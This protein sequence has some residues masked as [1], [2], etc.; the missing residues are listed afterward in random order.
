MEE[1]KQN[2]KRVAKL[3]D[4]EIEKVFDEEYAQSAN[5]STIIK[6]FLLNQRIMTAGGGKRLRAAFMY[7]SYILFG[8]KNTSEILKV[9][10]SI[11]F[12]HA[13]LLIH[14][15][16]MDNANLRRGY[17]T[18]HSLYKKI[19]RKAQED[20][21][22]GKH[23]GNSIAINAGDS[24]SY[25]GQ[26]VLLESSF[27]ANKKIKAL[28]KVSRNIMDVVY[29]QVLDV[30]GDI[31][32]VDE[33]YVLTVHE[34]KTGYYT[35]ETP[36]HVGAILAGASDD[37]LKIL[38]EYAI[39]GGTAFQIVDD[40]IDLFGTFRQTGKL[41]GTDIKEGKNTL[42]TIKAFENVDKKDE[43][44]MKKH[45]GNRSIKDKEIKRFRD[46]IVSSGSLDYSKN[47]AKRLLNRSTKSLL[48]LN[49]INE[50]GTNFL[51]GI[52]EYMFIRMENDENNRAK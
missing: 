4:A 19:Y 24:L 26:K 15:D 5:I 39:P 41:P 44:F 37:E 13:F 20:N 51:R 40:I 30:Y 42:L 18:I 21:R 28:E 16:I 17:H 50:E 8:G 3:V 38:T 22:G 25:L 43:R 47:M 34:Y 27:P 46:I 7:Y 32:D 6:D 31:L 2:L 33:K 9:S 52:N 10:T 29:G 11:E 14:D 48:K 23:F 35:Y 12:I 1:A 45:L 49:D 36:L